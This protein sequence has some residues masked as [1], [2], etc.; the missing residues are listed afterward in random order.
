[1]VSWMAQTQTDRSKRMKLIHSILL[2][3]FLAAPVILTGCKTHRYAGAPPPAYNVDEDLKQL[4]KTFRQS[5]SISDFYTPPL[6]QTVARR[7][8]FITGRLVLI[9][10]NYFKWLR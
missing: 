1:M 9:N 5:T 6:N 3:L 8:S 7:N 10:L 2:R 4:E